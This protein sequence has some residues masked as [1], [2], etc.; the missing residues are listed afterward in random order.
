FPLILASRRSPVREP[1]RA[2][3]SDQREDV[4]PFLAGRAPRC[5]VGDRRAPSP[6]REA[7]VGAIGRT[8]VARV[9]RSKPRNYLTQVVAREHREPGPAME[10]DLDP[11]M[12]RGETYRRLDLLTMY[13][14]L[15]RAIAF[16]QSG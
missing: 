14:T 6:R 11:E 4:V 7:V 8:G 16:S 15:T 3:P 2:G 1:R 13:R 5:G 9:C 10:L 12:L